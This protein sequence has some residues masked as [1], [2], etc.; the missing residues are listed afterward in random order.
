MITTLKDKLS[1]RMATTAALLLCLAGQAAA[2]DKVYIEDFTIAPG[3]TKE[4]A[5]HFD[6]DATDYKRLKG[7]ILM[8]T[9]L[10]VEDNAYG[11]NVRVKCNVDRTNGALVA[12]RPSTGAITFTGA[13]FVAGTDAFAYMTVTAGDD[14]A[15]TSTITLSGFTATK[16]DG[17]TVD[18]T[19]G[20]ATVTL[21][22]ED[23][24]P[25]LA[26]DPDVLTLAPGEEASVQVVLSNATGLAGMQ[27]RFQATEGLTITGI[28]T[29][30][31]GTWRYKEEKGTVALL[32][33]LSDGN[34][35]TV[36]LKADDG[37]EGTATLTVDKVKFT[38]S[39][40]VSIDGE[41]ATLEVTI[42]KNTVTLSE[43]DE[44]WTALEGTATVTVER[45]LRGGKWNTLCLPFDLSSD[46]VDD[47]FGSD[48]QV[49]EL[50]GYAVTGDGDDTTIDVSFTGVDAITHDR[51][52]VIKPASDMTEF[53]AE[54]VTLSSNDG[55][56][57]AASS[58]SEA[59]ATGVYQAGKIPANS[60]FIS[61]DKFYYSKG[62]TAIK[63][64]YAYF[65]LPDADTGAAVRI[66]V[67][68]SETT[69]ISVVSNGEPGYEGTFTLGGV[70]V[71]RPVKGVS[72]SNGKKV[73][74]K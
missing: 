52:V 40:A 72:V 10:T 4:I 27:A 24:A 3:E 62:N 11:T 66:L 5:I 46:Q 19:S 50:A 68:G 42:E 32:G 73:F 33:T 56:V 37:Y 57:T 23:T 65:T 12:Y 48:A 61:D 8:P 1:A 26:F 38:T 7:T 29:S 18:I 17:S 25:S 15:E 53:T 63:C 47:I 6:T 45:Q 70:R 54:A 30:A 31:A 60:L 39:S 41:G 34:F 51:P 49:Y 9:G 21:G 35:I 20:D 43:G 55:N 67:D 64:S 16:V 13:T 69:G 22:T 14:L 71:D 28:T 36:A 44:D 58:D 2:E 74:K 59:K